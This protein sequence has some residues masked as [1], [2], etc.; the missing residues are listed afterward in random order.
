MLL[1]L[2]LLPVIV[3]Q[4]VDYAR[5]AVVSPYQEVFPHFCLKIIRLWQ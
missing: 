1:L 4:L 2:L 5:Q 3:G